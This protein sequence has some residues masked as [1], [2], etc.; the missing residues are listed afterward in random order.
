[1]RQID[2]TVVEV[3]A[4]TEHAATLVLSAGDERPV[5][6]AGQFLTIDPHQFRSLEAVTAYLE[7]AKGRTEPPRAYSLSSA[8]DEPEMAV[9]IKDERFV[10]RAT[11]YP[12]LLSPLLV[13]GM[14]TGMPLAVRGF[15]G[16]YVLPDDVEATTDHVVHVCAGSGSVPNLAILKYALRHHAGLRHT[17]IYSNRTWGDIIFRA[18][19]SDL[20]EAFPSRLHLVHAL[21]R[22][23]PGGQP[24]GDIHFGRVDADLVRRLV[25]DPSAALFY[26]CG[27]AIRK[28][29][30]AAARARGTE[31]PPQFMESMKALLESLQVEPQRILTES[32]G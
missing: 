29:N 18:Q 27:P 10:P 15:T 22:E 11:Q 14:A 17:F 31:P 26:V 30:R 7:D 16:H 4:E 32:Y 13:H 23:E 21:T 28:W 20:V 1:M 3:V 8:P 19:L 6:R 5:Y 2:A 24:A 12:P 9:T 25:P